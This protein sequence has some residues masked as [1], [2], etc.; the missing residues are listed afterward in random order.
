M[1][2]VSFSTFRET[3]TPVLLRQK[4]KKQRRDTG[5]ERYQTAIERL[6]T[7]LSR[8][9][10]IFSDLGRALSRPLRLLIFHPI[11]QITALISAFNYGILYIVLS[12]FASLWTHQYGLSVELSGLHYLAIALG[13][14]AGS[15][16]GGPLMDWLF[17][18]M[19]ARSA[20]SDEHIP[21]FRIPLT[22]LGTILAP[23]GMFMYGWTAQYNVQWVAVDAGVFILTFGMQIAGMPLQAY[24]IDIYH[25]HTSSA[26]AATQFLKSLTAF[27]FPLFA[28]S[29]Y[30]ALHYGWA[31]SIL[32]FVGLLIGVPAPLVLWYFGAKF[33]SR[34]FSTY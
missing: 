2:F 12:S 11:I 20:T 4:A 33:R 18:Y 7:G 1:T 16:L 27:L 29:M 6:S 8:T 30:R 24:I 31:N 22:C 28:P 26:M 15:Q 9:N 19:R 5:D 17:V 21:E 14:I 25:E 3:Y 13:E 23:L 32:G 34:A 10:T